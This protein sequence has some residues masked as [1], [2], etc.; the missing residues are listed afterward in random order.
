MTKYIV[1]IESYVE[2]EADDQEK[3]LGIVW[4][5]VTNISTSSEDV[6]IVPQVWYSVQNEDGEELLNEQIG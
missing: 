4:D 2:I 5:S 6:V 3:V 1:A